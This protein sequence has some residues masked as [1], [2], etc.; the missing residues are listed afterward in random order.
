MVKLDM[1]KYANVVGL[2]LQKPEIQECIRV[3]A[4]TV[5]WDFYR[6]TFSN[7]HV[8]EYHI[9][10]GGD[11][12]NITRIHATDRRYNKA[13]VYLLDESSIV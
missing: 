1:D 13:N 6:V 3:T 4:T 9:N 5:S 2:L 12:N 10:Y 8:L 11:L 7:N